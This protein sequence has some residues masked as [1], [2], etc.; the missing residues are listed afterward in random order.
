MFK[1]HPGVYEPAGNFYYIG[2]KWEING[3]KDQKIQVWEPV[4]L[5]DGT[6]GLYKPK[7]C[8]LGF[9]YNLTTKWVSQSIP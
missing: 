3:Q 9:S 2:G 1:Y 7:L 4:C 5:W 8:Y 6:G